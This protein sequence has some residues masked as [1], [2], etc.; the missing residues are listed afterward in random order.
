MGMNPDGFLR[1][2]LAAPARL[3]ALLDAYERPTS[4]L[5]PLAGPLRDARRILLLGMGSS[6]F[7]AE[8]VAA[9]L[10]SEG[11]DAVAE[12][13]STG[14]P[15]APRRGTLVVGISAS[16]STPET[17]DAFARHR[18]SGVLV[19]V[20]NRPESALGLA[21]DHVLPLLAGVEEGGVSCLT[22]QATLAVLLRLAG[23]GGD[24]LRPAVEAAAALRETRHEWLDELVAL[25]ERA[26]TVYTIAPAE[27]TSSA[28]QSAL[29]F[30]EGP[31]RPAAATETGDWLHVDVYLSKRPG[32][33]A[34]LFPGSRFD[35]AVLDWLTRRSARVVSVGRAWPVQTWSC[36][37]RTPTTLSCSASSKRESR[38]SSPPNSGGVEIAAG[39]E[40]LVEFD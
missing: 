3:S 39:D 27:R 2:V 11:V 1:D 7:A 6:R 20:T 12:L 32:Y 23:V 25:F 13:A 30:R 21:A 19:A 34:L 22:F 15:A 38:N 16:G 14:A 17:V 31:R 35:D 37:S 29:M 36:R 40:A 9:R 10:R 4:P 8:T 26:S 18:G 28:L 5:R 33:T 24:R